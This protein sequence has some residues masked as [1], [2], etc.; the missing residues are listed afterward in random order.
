MGFSGIMYNRNV[1]IQL[2]I[3]LE[4][5]LFF[6]CVHI[7]QRCVLIKISIWSKKKKGP[8]LIP[9]SSFPLLA[10]PFRLF[11]HLGTWGAKTFPLLLS[12]LKITLT[13]FTIIVTNMIIAVKL[14]MSIST[15][16]LSV[17]RFGNNIYRCYLG[18]TICMIAEPDPILCCSKVL[19][20]Y[21][22]PPIRIKEYQF[23]RTDWFLDQCK[24][25]II[26]NKPFW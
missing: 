16:I 7:L 13:V 21:P 18:L 11:I 14:I 15:I 2:Y 1:R 9:F 4:N 23:R 6:T 24:D 17:C 19:V 20:C 22:V 25:P 10:I 8:F 3:T 12:G 5:G 26:E